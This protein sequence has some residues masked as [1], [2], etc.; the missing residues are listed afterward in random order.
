V[1]AFLVLTFA[2]TWLFWSGAIPFRGQPLLVT[3]LVLIGGFG[4]AL[5]AV[6]TQRLRSG[7]GL[8]LSTKRVTVMCIYELQ[9]VD[10][11]GCGPGI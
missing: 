4:P 1:V 3:S 11:I 8:D 6:E 5:A 7:L 10:K 2:W 9:T